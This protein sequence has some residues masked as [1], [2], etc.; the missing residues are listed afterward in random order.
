ME[1][2]NNILEPFGRSRDYRGRI[3]ERVN[4]FELIPKQVYDKKNSDRSW[5][6][7]E[8]PEY[9]IN[10]ICISGDGTLGD[11]YKVGNLYIGLPSATNKGLK[12]GELFDKHII[13]LDID[14]NGNPIDEPIS[15][16]ESKWLR[17]SPPQAFESLWFKYKREM[18]SAR[19]NQRVDARESFVRDRDN[20]ISRHRAFVES[21]FDKR[22]HGL[23]IKIDDDIHYFTGEYWM[24]LQHYYLTESN[25]FP[26]FR[27]TQMEALWHWEAV[28]AD[29]RNWGEIRGKGRRTSWS[30]ESASMA[31]N[32]FTITSYAEIPIVSERKDLA[33]KLFNGKIVKSFEYYPIYF[34]PLIDLPNDEA[35]SKLTIAQETERRETSTIDFYPTKDTAYDSTKVKNISINDEIGKWVDVSLTEFIS[36]HSKCH[37]EGGATARFGSTAGNYEGGGGREFETEFNDANAL[38]RNAL[39]RTKNGLISF[40]IDVCYTMTEPIKYFDKWGY[41]IVFDPNEPIENEDGKI[42][43]FGA[44]THWNITFNDLKGKEQKQKLNGFLRDTPREPK[45]MFRSE[46]GKNNDF[47]IGNLNNNLDYL[48]GFTDYDWKEKMFVGNFRFQ[49]EKYNSPVEWI[50]D[51]NGKF[52]T[53]WLPEKDDQNKYSSKNFHGKSIFMPD[54]SHIGCFGVD[55]YDILGNTKDSRGSDGAIVGFTKFNMSG[56][57]TNSFFL[58]YRERP[59]KRDDFYDDV[60]MAC[61]FYGFYALIESNKSRILEYMYDNNLTGFA[62]RRPDKKWKDLSHTEKM[63]GGIPSSQETVQD[64]VSGLQDYISDFVGI[65]VE[66]DCKVYHK[67]LIQ[68]WIEL[69]PRN[70]QEH[71][72]A[73]ASGLAKMGAQHT[74]KKRYM[75]EFLQERRG[76]SF[77]DF[78]A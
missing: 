35:Q 2:E 31:L 56:S 21:E 59:K 5:L 28:R 24:F 23:F 1:L 20:L 70:R 71:D 7:K 10:F 41:S 54:N 14:H 39:G 40:F 58:T 32:N 53:T 67:D 77:A 63:W 48:D 43:E 57:P 66:N 55:S 9:N 62:L 50:P 46:G 78:G 8:Y 76:L 15:D 37:T 33:Y 69:K 44:I 47:D 27:V 12:D 64:Q 4:K 22:E 30:V 49:G 16:D 42:V 38:D 45:H 52:K 61:M 60:I 11:I 73:V 74:E 25:C 26:K 34:K 3:S 68:D 19:A 72:L 65:N 18:S 75:P 29:S 13:N 51:P 6:K 36:R 17:Q